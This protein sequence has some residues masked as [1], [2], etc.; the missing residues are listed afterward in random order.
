VA[1]DA[2]SPE[3]VGRDKPPTP[4]DDQGPLRHRSEPRGKRLAAL[5]FLALGVVYGDIG[6]SPLYAIREAFNPIYG[7][8]VTQANVYG[9]LSLVLW[10]L[11]LVVS[12]KYMLLVLRADNRGEGG[13]LSLLALNLQ[14]KH[15]KADR[16]MRMLVITLGLIGAALLYG[17]TM[18]T[19]AISVLSAMEG[20]EVIAPALHY[21]VIPLTVLILVGLFSFQS[22]GTAGVGKFFG[23]IAL[24]WFITIGTLGAAEIFHEPR[25]LF[26][27][28]PHYGI[29]FF[30]RNGFA[31]FL[32]LGAVVLAVT[33]AEALYADMGHFGR[34]P[35]RR[36]WFGLVLPALL[37]NYFGQGALVLRDPSAAANPFYLLAPEFF[38]Y[39]LVLLA[40]AATIV[41]SQALISGAYSLTRQCAQLGYCP[42]VRIVHTSASE[43][44]QIYIP[45][46]N[47]ALMTGALLMVLGFQSSARIASAYGVAATGVFVITTILLF[48]LAR[49]WWEWSLRKSLLLLIPFFIIDVGFF[50]ANLQKV[51]HGGWVPIVTGLAIFLLMTTWNRGRTIVTDLLKRATLPM[52]LFLPDV[53]KRKPVRVPGVAVFLTS[54]PEGAPGVLLHHLKHNKT[55][56]ERV[57]LLSILTT[58]VPE[59]DD[60][61]R[62]AVEELGEGFYRIKARYG[63]METPNVV[64]VMEL[65]AKAGLEAKPA[66]VSYYLGRERLLPSGRSQMA[67]W[68]K[69][70]YIVMSRN[71]PSA[72]E[73][74]GIPPNRAVELGAQFEM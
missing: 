47:W 20:I 3:A 24:L 25:T 67:T 73:Y 21:A 68:R 10:S 70:L 59:I 39:P 17:E 6:T 64:R 22:R 13:I 30:V 28:S 58:E 14:R 27:L 52:D 51:L 15:R 56:H 40:T 7:I 38:Q 65:A 18:I 57:A 43:F 72:A 55:L 31:G 63:F 61:S 44:G 32:V 37:L 8:A 35:I 2:G 5:T 71:S 48:V 29:S 1:I 66:D 11:L 54:N 41:A 42:R 34:K 46:V 45:G 50:T 9:I 53:A 19:P 74:F 69:R 49:S 36:A 60:E 62:V 16:S 23:P 12:V 26:A 4:P 33:G